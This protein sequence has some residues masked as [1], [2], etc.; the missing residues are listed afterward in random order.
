MNERWRKGILNRLLDKYERTEA[1]KRGETPDRRIML[2]FYGASKSDFPEYDIDNHFVRSDINETVIAM[3]AEGLIDFEWFRGEENHIIKR[4]W[5]N[6]ERIDSA[7][8]AADRRSAKAVAFAVIRELEREI[9]TVSTEW[10]IAYYSE[11][12]EYI[13]EKIQLGSRISADGNERRN[14]FHMLRFIDGNSLTSL[15][16]RVFSEKCFGDS[17]FFET[18]M[19][20]T[21]LSIMRKYISREMNDAELLQS[22]GISRYPEPLEMRGNTLVNGNNMNALK[23]G[24]CIYSNDIEVANILIPDNVERILTIENRANFFAYQKA[25]DELVIFHGGQYSPAKKRLFEKIAAAMPE[26]CIWYHWG[27]ID[28]GGFSMLLRL[29]KEIM[30]SIQPYR[31]SKNELIAFQSFTQSFSKEYAEK[32]RK[33]SEQEQLSDC[34]VCINYMLEHHIKLEQEAM[35]T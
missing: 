17:K 27:D 22:I 31:M 3:K 16:E 5:L 2:R 1:F 30:P 34:R 15:T 24:F 26:N 8:H 13:Q 12:K 10:M 23:G 28:L 33:L 25:E 32:L 7:Y 29:R 18:K 19:K 9:D 35:L 6:V 20:S 11:T 14:L 4:L 21:L